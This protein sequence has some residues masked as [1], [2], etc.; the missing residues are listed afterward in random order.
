MAYIFEVQASSGTHAFAAVVVTMDESHALRLAKAHLA[1]QS[2]LFVGTDFAVEQI[3]TAKPGAL[4]GVR[5]WSVTPLEVI[6]M[7]PAVSS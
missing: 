3:G 1:S 5:A 7:D 2:A 6:G 4:R